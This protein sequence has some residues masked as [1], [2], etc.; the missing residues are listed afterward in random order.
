MDI[1]N[2]ILMQLDTY[3]DFALETLP[4]LVN[5]SH[6]ILSMSTYLL[7]KLKVFCLGML[8]LSPA[9]ARN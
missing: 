4:L 1:P 5:E 2:L 8:L 7:A 6:A 9:H 3:N